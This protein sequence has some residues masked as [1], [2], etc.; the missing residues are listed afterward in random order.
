VQ[1]KAGFMRFREHRFP[2]EMPARLDH[3]SFTLQVSVVNIS[4]HGARIS[5]V[6]ALPVGAQV[7]LSILTHHLAGEVRWHRGKLAG[8]RLAEPL[9]PVVLATI[10]QVRAA[11]GSV[12]GGKAGGKVGATSMAISG[13][14]SGAMHRRSALRPSRGF[15]AGLTEM[16]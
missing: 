6:D 5:G 15:G 16:R 14:S 7:R 11:P 8:L 3:G 4:P 13:A 10:R 9:S 2:C 1:N 12:A